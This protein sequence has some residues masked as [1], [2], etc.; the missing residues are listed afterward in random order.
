MKRMKMLIIPILCLVFIINTTAYSSAIGVYEY[1]TENSNI[2]VTF[3]E[4]SM[5]N[6]EQQQLIADKLVYG[7]SGIQT[8]AWCWLTG[9]SLV[10]DAVSVVTHK[11]KATS[12]RCYREMYNV[13]SCEKCDYMEQ[14]LLGT[15]YIVCCPEE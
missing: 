7:D 15:T 14:E 6:T 1:E 10:H 13:T 12:P 9:H 4:D 2:V 8:Y 3:S 11:K 5:L